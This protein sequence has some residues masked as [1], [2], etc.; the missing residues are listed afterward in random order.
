MERIAE[1]DR[2]RRE[3]FDK[4]YAE[5]HKKQ[6]RSQFT[7]LDIPTG[8]MKDNAG[9]K[10]GI[11]ASY[12]ENT[13]AGE[14]HKAYIYQALVKAFRKSV[15]KN[16]NAVLYI[17]KSDESRIN[18][19]L[20]DW[21]ANNELKARMWA[22]YAQRMTRPTVFM[23]CDIIV[24][25]DL[26]NGFQSSGITI[27]RRPDKSWFN[28]GAIWAMP[29]P[30][31]KAMF[32]R[33]H[34]EVEYLY[35]N[36]SELKRSSRHHV[37]LHQTSFIRLLERDQIGCEVKVIDGNVWN[38]TRS[39]WSN[40]GPHTKV[41]HATKVLRQQVFLEAEPQRFIEAANCIKEWVK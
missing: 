37:G 3:R 33:W 39:C 20:R 21:F 4:F 34:E 10:Y 41:L 29:T 36:E 15:R 18:R 6:E 13:L 25:D 30:E 5:H 23:D 9:M 26:V 1:H 2:I 17:E 19:K 27:T 12:F 11:Y 22:E 32:A 38:S 8:Q 31:V 40:F 14:H 16:T 35:K 24:L 7:H 28:S